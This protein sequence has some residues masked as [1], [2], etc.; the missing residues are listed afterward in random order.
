[1]KAVIFCRVSTKE[2]GEEGHSLKAQLNATKEYCEKKGF[3]L[4]CEPIQIM[5]S[6]SK[7]KRPEFEKMLN[8]IEKSK[9]KQV[10]LVCYAVD[11]LP[12]DLKSLAELESLVMSGKLE[13]H[14]I[15]ENTILN[16]D[17]DDFLYMINAL[18]AR[19]ETKV[20]GK[21]VKFVFNDKRK[22]G[23][24]CGDSPLGYINKQRKHEKKKEKREPVEVYIDP[25]RGPLMKQL[26]IDYSNGMSIEIAR[27][28]AI[29]NGLTSKKGCKPSMSSIEQYLSNPFYCGYLYSKKYDTKTPHNYPKL[30]TEELFERCQEIRFGKKRKKPKS[31]VK[32]LYT[33]CHGRLKC[34]HCGASYS[35]ETK[36][37]KSG[38][39][40]RYLRTKNKECTYCHEVRQEIV[41]SQVMEVLSKMTIDKDML[42]E[43]KRNLQKLVDSHYKDNVDSLKKLTSR[44]LQIDESLKALRHKQIPMTIRSDEYEEIEQ[45]KK[46]LHEEKHQIELKLSQLNQSDKIFEITFNTILDISSRASDL[47]KSSEIGRKRKILDLLFPNLSLSGENLHYSL[48]KP[49]NEVLENKENLVWLH[50]GSKLR[51]KSYAGVV[52]FARRVKTMNFDID[53]L[54]AAT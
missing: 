22:E 24:L 43:I 12:R 39:V 14:S 26:F 17:S 11:R 30:I 3:E 23:V 54:C 36:I 16:E 29:K 13:I 19:R 51:T 45:T 37:K 2:Q 7:A 6:A 38:R 32:E 33:F 28:N 20:L 46:E 18:M 10:A 41:E 27:I 34:H 42:A 49:F 1:M 47:F 52:N 31:N 50:F 9:Q 4:L 53:R 15:R 44:Q 48:R 35:G 5:E 40:Y 25:I 8:F 21:R